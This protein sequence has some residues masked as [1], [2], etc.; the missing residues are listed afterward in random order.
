MEN[1]T[2]IQRTSVRS[3]QGE[4]ELLSAL[5]ASLAALRLDSTR[6]S[7]GRARLRHAIFLRGPWGARV[8]LTPVAEQ[9]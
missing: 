9:T 5:D 6:L 1:R 3:T 2:R 4:D 7:V 8:L